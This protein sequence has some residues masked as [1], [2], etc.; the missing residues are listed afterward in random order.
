MS[1]M[2]DAA[3]LDDL[4]VTTID[5]VRGYRHAADHSTDPRYTEFFEA[6]VAERQQVVDELQA[7]SRVM[8][9]TP[10]EHGSVAGGVHRRILDIRTAFGGGDG[11]ILSEIERGEDYLK[12]EFERVLADGAIAPDVLESVRRCYQSVLHGHSRAHAL[13]GA[14]LETQRG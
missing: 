10:N 8:G 1:R 6:M 14:L 4:I 13:R 11:A 2:H 3:K 9:A 7:E 5:S 12:E